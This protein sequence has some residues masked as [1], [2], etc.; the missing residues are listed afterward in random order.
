MRN[1]TLRPYPAR[2]CEGI[3]DNT[4]TK[5]VEYDW[6]VWGK[7]AKVRR[8]IRAGQHLDKRIEWQM[9]QLNPCCHRD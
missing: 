7:P 4:G 2:G 8:S 6:D 1:G 3:V 9:V 5:I